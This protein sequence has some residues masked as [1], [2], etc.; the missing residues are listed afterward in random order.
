MEK[1]GKKERKKK[2]KKKNIFHRKNIDCQ[3]HKQTNKRF[4]FISIS[5]LVNEKTNNEL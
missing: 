5:Y 3:K 4:S 2:K 1:V